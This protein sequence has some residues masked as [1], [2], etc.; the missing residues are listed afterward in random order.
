MYE[1][2]KNTISTKADSI[3]LLLSTIFDVNDSRYNNSAEHNNKKANRHNSTTNH[4][5]TLLNVII[6]INF[7]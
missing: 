7:Q 3:N 6:I 4:G 1:N 2:I 5:N